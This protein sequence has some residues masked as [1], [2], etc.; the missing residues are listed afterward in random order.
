MRVGRL[1]VKHL[2]VIDFIYHKYVRPR[3]IFAIIAIIANTIIAA[4]VQVLH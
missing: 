1:S 2:Y 4:A 3:V